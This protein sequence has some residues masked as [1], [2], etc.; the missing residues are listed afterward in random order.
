MS[1]RAVD[2]RPRRGRRGGGRHARRGPG[3]GRPDPAGWPG[4]T[5]PAAGSSSPTSNTGA[6]TSSRHRSPSGR[7]RPAPRA[8][9][10]PPSRTDSGWS[11]L[12]RPSRSLGSPRPGR[13]CDSTTASATRPDG[14]GPGPWPTTRRP[15]AA[16]LYRL[17][18]DGTATR[19]VDGVT[20]SNGLAWSADG[21]TMYYVDTPT[22]RIDA[23]EFTASTGAI[24]N[25]HP[26]VHIPLADGAPDGL[27][28]DAEGGLWVA[29]WGGGAVRSLR[30][31]PPR[32]SHPA[33]GH[34]ANQLH[35]RWRQP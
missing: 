25:R 13:A 5:S 8:G 24:G 20:I 19:M 15:G 6:A 23:F 35:V 21:R 22:Q 16:A 2:D 27:T 34:P 26:V 12:D 18:P 9:S 14:S 4:S 1:A 29:L 10:W 28:I 3:L 30:G 33:A 17:D 32:P 11:G 31:R 7:S